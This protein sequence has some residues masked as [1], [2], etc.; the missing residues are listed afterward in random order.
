ML[1]SSVSAWISS[2]LPSRPHTSNSDLPRTGGG[3]PGL[4]NHLR[5]LQVLQF[6]PPTMARRF[7]SAAKVQRVLYGSSRRR[8]WF[9]SPPS[10]TLSNARTLGDSEG[11]MR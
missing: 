5:M 6:G 7:P 2:V 4:G 1:S 11:L 3:L 8:F 10:L 9:L